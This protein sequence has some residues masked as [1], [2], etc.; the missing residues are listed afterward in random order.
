VKNLYVISAK[1]FG[2]ESILGDEIYDY[3][4]FPAIKI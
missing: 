2:F 3:F 1:N 4:A